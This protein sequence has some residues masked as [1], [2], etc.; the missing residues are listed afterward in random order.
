MK[1]TK[2]SNLHKSHMGVPTGT[3]IWSDAW[4]KMAR[5]APWRSMSGTAL[6]T[7]TLASHTNQLWTENRRIS[8]L[9]RG[10]WF[11]STLSTRLLDPPTSGCKKVPWPIRSGGRFSSRSVSSSWEG[12][13]SSFCCNAKTLTCIHTVRI[14]F[15]CWVLL[16]RDAMK[17]S[18]RS[19]WL[20]VEQEV[21]LCHGQP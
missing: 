7:T 14:N 17:A 1:V 8:V 3:S 21:G 16:L 11:F 4:S 10:M 20:S 12:T 15:E 18:I 5:F 13:C 2:R 19:S 9:P 6:R